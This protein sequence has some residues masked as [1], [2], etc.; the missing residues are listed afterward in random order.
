MN[1]QR[2]CPEEVSGRLLRN[3]GSPLRI[4]HGIMSRKTGNLNEALRIPESRI[5]NSFETA[6]GR[7]VLKDAASGSKFITRTGNCMKS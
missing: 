1:V 2:R 6:E 4:L 5:L 3:F 7:T